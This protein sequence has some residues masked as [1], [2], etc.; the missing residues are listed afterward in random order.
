M[1][2]SESILRDLR[3]L[4][5]DAPPALRERVRALGEP[6]ARR[7]LPSVPW[8]RSLAVLAPASALALVVAAVVHGVASSNAPGRETLGGRVATSGESGTHFG[9]A[10]VGTPGALRSPLLP[11]SPG[12]RQDYEATMTLRVRDLDALTD[13]TNEAMRI[14]RSFGGY[15]ASVRQSTA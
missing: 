1:A 9:A 11:P 4:Q 6:P 13:Q 8:R 2:T 15:V 10:D 12:R 5:L 3:T 14:V 7:S